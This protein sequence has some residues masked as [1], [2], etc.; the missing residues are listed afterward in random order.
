MPGTDRPLVSIIVPTYNE[1]A[2]IGRTMDAL[3]AQT[4]R[5]LEVIVVDA[6]QDRTPEIVTSYADRIPDLRLIRQRPL[7]GVS[8]ARN[9]GL[10]AARGE[11]VVILNA[12]VFP[13]P[14]FV[15]RIVPHYLNGADYLSVESRVANVERVFPRYIQAQHAYDQAHN[16]DEAAWTEGFSCRREAALRAGGFP[17]HFG[18][19]TAGED[20]VFTEGLAQ[21]GC[22]GARDFS[23]VV[24]H[25]APAAFG[26]YW[27]QRLGRGRGGAYR[28]YAHEKRPLRWP[29]VARSVLGTWL[30]AALLVPALL[31]G[32]RLAAYSPRGQGDWLALA[33]ARLVEMVATGA[34]Y[35]DGCREIERL[36]L[37][38][39]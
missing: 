18:R 17:E 32:W 28:L 11:I 13:H 30:L 33:W 37:N 3:A 7:P 38:R 6:S 21:L 39:P 26:E 22:R 12:D 10:R 27:R 1:E 14:D 8:V 35:W 31:Q 2:D 24:P 23:I 9:D 20:G 5:P 19:N 25:V 4:Y 16:P 36:G 34:G 15:E 29:A